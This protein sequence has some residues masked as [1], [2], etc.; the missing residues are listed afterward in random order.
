MNNLKNKK[1]LILGFSTT[2]IA[3][4]KY[5]IKKEAQVYISEF[6][7]L[8]EKNISLANELK[9]QGINLEFNGHSENFINNADFCILSPSIPTDAPVLAKL[10]EKNI[11]YFSDLEYISKCENEKIILITGTNGKT[12]TTALTSHILSK[13]YNAP[14]CGN[15]GISPIEYKD[16]NV[17]YYVI[18][19]SSYQ[20]NY[21]PELTPRIGI[22][23]NLTPDHILWHKTI[24]NYFEAKA[25]PFRNMGEN[26]FAILN[27]DDEKTKK[28]GEEIQAQVYYFSLQKQNI[29]NCIY[30]ENDEIIFYDEKIININELQ[31]VGPHNIQNAMCAILAAKIVGLDN[32][33][34]KESLKSFKAIEHRLEFVRTIEDTDYY[35]DSKATNPEASIVA[36]NSFDNKKVVLIAGGRDKKTTL[37]DFITAVKERI[38][39]VIL[40]GEATQRFKNELAQN[41]YI[42]IVNSKTLEEAIDI[43][44]L[45][46]PDVVL[47]SPACASFDM[48]ESYEKRGEAFRNYVLSK[49]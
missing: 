20:L 13:K 21:S 2:G 36:I 28:L 48:F 30:L 33:K 18:E 38:S 19:A 6:K 25:K 44:S 12:T 23:T 1:I 32:D 29:P 4:A 39:K 47:L 46:K 5:F 16:K 22:F 35:N 26:S 34:I 40:I 11:P 31:I 45:D 41:G 24:E 43:A 49:K 37:K 7:E 15:I 3:A 17:D 9:I 27:Y 10:E 42:N 8:E 14:Y